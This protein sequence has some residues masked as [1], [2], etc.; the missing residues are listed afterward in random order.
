MTVASADLHK[1]VIA[2]WNASGLDALFQ[3]LYNAGVD[4]S[5]FTVL[6]D[7]E[8]AP[9]QPFPYCVFQQSLGLTTSRMSGPGACLREIR[10][11]PWDFKVHAKAVSGDSR[12]PKGIAAYLV[13]EIMKVFGGHPTINPTDLSLDNGNFLITQYQNDFGIRTGDEEY[14]WNLSYIF[15]LDVPVAA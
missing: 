10:D 4:S 14:Q 9:G 12:T 2:V 1:G 11:T 15:R 8:G 13:D 7:Q 3:A 5:E 6:N